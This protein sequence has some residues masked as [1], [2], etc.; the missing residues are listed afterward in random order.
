MAIFERGVSQSVTSLVDLLTL[1]LRFD[2]DSVW[3]QLLCRVL[4]D[5]LRRVEAGFKRLIALLWGL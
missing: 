1:F 5:W 4:R 3:P 2:L